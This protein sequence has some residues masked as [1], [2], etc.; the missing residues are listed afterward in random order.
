MRGDVIIF[1][2]IYLLIKMSSQLRSFTV[3][4][5]R[6]PRGCRSR[7]S[8]VGGRYLSRSPAAAAKKALS[9]ACRGRKTGG[10]C[11]FVVEMRETTQGSLKK[12]RKYKVKRVKD[13]IVVEHNGEEVVH[14]Y[15]TE[16][17]AYKKS[18]R[19][20]RRKAS[21]KRSRRSQ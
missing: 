8:L 11:S 15:R 20:C 19:R 6:S 12:S 3:V 7:P 2:I 4:S 9:Q 18:Q 10:Q 14:K 21:P 17:K 16:A 13:P 5:A 1:I